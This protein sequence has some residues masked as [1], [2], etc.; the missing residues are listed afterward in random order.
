MI[1]ARTSDTGPDCRASPGL[2]VLE[3]VTGS[4][5]FGDG[6]SGGRIQS[7]ADAYT[8]THNVLTAQ[9]LRDLDR[10][11]LTGTVLDRTLALRKGI[12]DPEL[13]DTAPRAAAALEE[14]GAAIRVCVDDPGHG[15]L[16]FRAHLEGLVRAHQVA[17]LLEPQM[18]EREKERQR[19][20]P[21]WRQRPPCSPDG[22]STRTT[23]RNA[24]RGSPRRSTGSSAPT[25]TCDT[26]SPTPQGWPYR[27]PYPGGLQVTAVISPPLRAR[28][29]I[30]I[31]S[32]TAR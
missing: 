27:S 5:R 31:L 3:S 11:G 22:T 10:M 9:V 25:S 26:G 13:G 2:V 4:P 1:P 7:V 28:P 15:A 6:P 24:T 8:G 21:S 20:P 23:G 16:H 14:L 17:L 30:E 29:R 32:G 12:T 19:T 18:E